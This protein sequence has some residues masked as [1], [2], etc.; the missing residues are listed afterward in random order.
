MKLYEAKLK[1]EKGITKVS[2]VQNPAVET[3][4]SYFATETETPVY[5]INEEKQVIYSVAMR[6]DKHIFRKDVNG[7][8][9]NVYFS[10]ETVEQ[11]QQSYFKNNA[12]A[13][14]NLN[15]DAKD[16]DG[17][18]PFESWIV[19]DENQDK[20]NFMKIEAKK[21]DWI[22]G[23][24]IENK[25][26]WEKFIKTGEI[27]GLSIEA[28]LDYEITNPQI[29]MNTEK[30]KENF[31]THLKNFFMDEPKEEEVVNMEDAPATDEAPAE[32]VET[33]EQWKEK[34]ELL[35]A[36]NADLKEKLSTLEAKAVEEGA[37]LETMKAEIEKV[38]QEVDTFKAE[39]IAIKN[40]PNEEKKDFSKMTPLE[41]FRLNK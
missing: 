1:S 20:S 31:F 15:H 30:T 21:G 23:F 7:E 38:K 22:M 34:Y 13:S 25:E 3:K 14:T 19:A 9:A 17:I 8:P 18:F 12:N 26:V 5:F 29:N 39:A 27:D 11:C 36:E 10:A 4:L 2:L 28:F 37:E 33:V 32:A 24:K 40:V 16:T 41:K 6:P 35:E